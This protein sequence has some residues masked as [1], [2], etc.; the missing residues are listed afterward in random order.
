[1][2]KGEGEGGESEGP[3]CLL[4]ILGNGCEKK[5]GKKG[6][7]SPHVRV[8]RGRKKKPRVSL[9]HR[10]KKGEKE[11]G[12]ER[13]GRGNRCRD[14]IPLSKKKKRGGGREEKE[15]KEKRRGKRKKEE[16][17]L[18]RPNCFFENK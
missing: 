3:S 9:S 1:M 16:P 12:R 13:K 15:R 17:L 6:E 14:R 11:K 5:G 7:K 2:K 8:K 18:T 10:K 4:H